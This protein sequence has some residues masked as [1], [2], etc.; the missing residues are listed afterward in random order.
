[1]NAVA[2]ATMMT[3]TIVAIA[4]VP[5]PGHPAAMTTTT[6]GV[7]DGAVTTM[8]AGATAV[9]DGSAIRKVTPR[10][11]AAAGTIRVMAVAA[12]TAIPRAIP[13][14][15]AAAGK[16]AIAAGAGTMTTTIIGHAGATRAMT[17]TMIAAVVVAMDGAAGSGIPA[18]IPKRHGVARAAPETKVRGAPC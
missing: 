8:T 4:D 16:T 10:L 5:H 18:V 2:S 1:M 12:G 9:A 3:T 7:E 13:R 14:P 6:T 17:T 15:R 11:R